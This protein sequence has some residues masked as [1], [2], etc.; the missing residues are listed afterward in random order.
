MSEEAIEKALRAAFDPPAPATVGVEEELM[1]LDPET[2]D[3]L[4]RAREV[5]GR[6]EGDR[7]FKPELP[8]A[9]IE[10]ITEPTV[11]VGSIADSLARGRRDLAE[12]ARGIG[13]LAAAGG[14]PF[15]ASEGALDGDE[16]FRMIHD[17]Y[18]SA[19][20]IQLVFGLH[21][22]VRVTGAERALAVH[23]ALRSYLGELG[24]LAA[25]APLQQGLDSGYASVRPR[26]SAALPRQGVPPAFAE[27]SD[28]ARA[29]EWG[30]AAGAVPEP[31]FW[32]WE[33]RLHPAFGTIEVRVPDQQTRARESAAVAALVHALVVDL[34]KRYDV[35]EPLTVHP[36][37][38]IAEN[39]WS[40][41]RYGL[42]GTLADL[43]TGERLSTRERIAQLIEKV[44]PSAPPSAEPA[45][46]DARSLVEKN[47]SLR[48][49][50]A[51]V[52]TPEEVTRSLVSQ[53]L[54]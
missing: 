43:E 20:R 37:W 31:R 47:G 49:R 22:H 23:N 48:Q 41:T 50:E 10:L 8:A 25:N 30:Q 18:G 26:V 4:P 9:Q 16:R 2:L 15:T 40:A 3:L 53:F 17:R 32:W 52:G 33:L 19:A 45:L 11:E 27:L 24:A 34:C 1:L 44:A 21:V 54:K 35:G 51:A 5:L 29:L 14:H 6:L 7:R 46:A 42:E 28:F 39:R 12:A 36:S 38:R 13:L